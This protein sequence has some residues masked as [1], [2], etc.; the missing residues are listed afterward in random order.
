MPRPAFVDCH[1]HVCPS[2]DDGAG[3]VAEGGVLCR[4]AARHGTG[5]LFATPHVWPHLPLTAEREAQLREAFAALRGR[6]GLELR[7]GFELTPTLALL[8]EDLRRYA[9]E[10][11][12]HV[13]VEV[14]FWTGFDELLLVGEHACACGLTPVIAHPERSE[15]VLAQPALADDL[16]ARGWL[17]QVNASSLLGRHGPAARELA[18]ALVDRDLASLVASDGHRQARPPHLDE[19]YDLVVGRVGEA[20]ANRLFDGSAL[21]LDAQ[22]RAA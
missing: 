5:I 13:L 3:S 19:A 20:R 16:A 17:L 4:E 11:T 15:D 9:L 22:S 12:G 2:G 6:A 8:D 14:P 10:G 7:L 21:G 1:S 18:F